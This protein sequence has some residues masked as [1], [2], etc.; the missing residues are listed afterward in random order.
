[1]TD[2]SSFRLRGVSSRIQLGKGGGH[3]RSLLGAIE[4]RDPSNSDYAITRG[5]PGVG[6]NDLVT[7]GQLGGAQFFGQD[8]IT[9]PKSGLEATTSATYQTY[10]TL[11]IPAGTL[12]PAGLY[13]IGVNWNLTASNP[14]TEPESRFVINSVPGPITVF[15]PR[16]SNALIP[17]SVAD[18]FSG[19]ANAID[20]VIDLQYRRRAGFGSAGI[21]GSL[22]EV[23]RVS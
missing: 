22:F 4:A 19:S 10:D 13:R 14:N 7:V 3:V 17:I 15:E 12:N 23:W 18:Y 8:L 9:R 1:M 16:A 2:V 11:T 6:P 20:I 21:N 5:A